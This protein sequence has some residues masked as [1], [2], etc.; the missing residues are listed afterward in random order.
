MNDQPGEP[1]KHPAQ[2]NLA[3]H[4]YRCRTANGSHRSFVPIPEWTVAN[5]LRPATFDC[6]TNDAGDIVRHLH[7]GGRYSRHGPAILP[8]YQSHIANGKNLRMSRHAE[9]GRNLY[10]A[11]AIAFDRQ[12]LR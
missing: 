9:I 1:G 6:M 5:L 2:M 8:K 3:D 11:G 4:C 10:P 7:R 12:L